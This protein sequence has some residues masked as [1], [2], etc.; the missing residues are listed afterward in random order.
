[1]KY[2]EEEITNAYE[3]GKLFVKCLETVSDDL[4]TYNLAGKEY[5]VIDEEGNCWIVG[6]E[7]SDDI[8]EIQILKYDPSFE[9]YIR[10]I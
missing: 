9:L 6:T 7:K 8:H 3:V 5:E 2:T 4:G 1:M 10:P